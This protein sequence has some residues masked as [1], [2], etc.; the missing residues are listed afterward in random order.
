[1]AT[2]GALALCLC[3]SMPA[4]GAEPNAPAVPP[5]P[6][7]PAFG[8]NTARSLRLAVEDLI[9]TYGDKYPNG[10]GFLARLGAIE[11]AGETPEN[12]SALAQLRREALQLMRSW[13]TAMPGERVSCVGCHETQL[14]TPPSSPAAFPQ[15]PPSEIEPWHGPTRGFSF[16][17]EV[18]PVL[19]QYCVGCHNGVGHANLHAV[20]PAVPENRTP[21]TRLPSTFAP[22]RPR[23][24]PR[25]SAWAT[26]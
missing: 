22:L 25:S 21:N 10:K 1:M 7:G 14:T 19:D 4:L 20:S 6:A 26:S 24:S 16:A 17:R 15:R 3:F 5:L 13:F 23:S 12:A 8:V 11:K 9:A 2:P 18:Q